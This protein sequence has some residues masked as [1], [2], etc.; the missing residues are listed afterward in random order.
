MRPV[1]LDGPGGPDVRQALERPPMPAPARGG[2]PIKAAAHAGHE[3]G[4][5]ALR[6]MVWHVRVPA[7]VIDEG[8]QLPGLIR[9]RPYLERLLDYGT[10]A[11]GQGQG[12]LPPRPIG[13]LLGGA[14]RP[15]PVPYSSCRGVGVPSRGPPLRPLCDDVRRYGTS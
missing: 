13:G 8:V 5:A 7:P 10:P 1:R 15:I 2:H 14:A 12:S 6:N 4:G 11:R 9:Q 3:T